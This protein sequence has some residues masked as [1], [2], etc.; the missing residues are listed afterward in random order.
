M[1]SWPIEIILFPVQTMNFSNEMNM[2]P[3][4]LN[5]NLSNYKAAQ[6]FFLASTGFK[7][8]AS[9]FAL[10]CSTSCAMKTIHWR[11]A[12]LLS[13]STCERNESQNE[14]MWTAGIQWNKYVT[15]AVESQ[16]I[17]KQLQSSQ[18]KWFSGL[19]WDLNP[20]TL[21]SC[22]SALPA[23]LWRPIHLNFSWAEPN[24]IS[25]NKYTKRLL[26]WAPSI[27]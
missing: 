18:K 21:R 19:R 4:Q 13:S 5:C 24:N 26:S 12:N 16:L 23:E 10:Q 22:C 6:K 11:Q 25:A 3:L 9:A 15:I 14:M 1:K 2:W 8:L 17:F 27:N 20:W 7:P